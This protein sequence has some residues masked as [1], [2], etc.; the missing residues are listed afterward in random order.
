MRIWQTLPETRLTIAYI[1]GSS[2][3]SGANY[4][5]CNFTSS[6]TLLAN[7]SYHIDF[8]ADSGTIYL[9]LPMENG[10]K[11]NPLATAPVRHFRMA[12]SEYETSGTWNVVSLPAS[13]QMV[14]GTGNSILM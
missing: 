8:E 13:A 2:F 10:E 12:T 5:S 11:A 1:A 7:Q 9:A 6:H 3:G 4:A 14:V